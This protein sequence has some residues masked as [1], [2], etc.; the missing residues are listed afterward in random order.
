MIK[1]LGNESDDALSNPATPKRKIIVS[2]S[3]RSTTAAKTI[4]LS[5]SPKASTAPTST[6]TPTEKLKP[7]VINSQP[8][9]LNTQV[10][11]QILDSL[12]LIQYNLGVFNNSLKKINEEQASISKKLTLIEQKVERNERLTAFVTTVKPSFLPFRTFEE[13]DAYDTFDD[14]KRNE[15]KSW[16][17]NFKNEVSIKET[18]RNIL[19]ENRLFAEDLIV[20]YVYKKES[21][22]GSKKAIIKKRINHDLYDYMVSTFPGQVTHQIW[23]AILQAALKAAD[24]RVSHRKK[25]EATQD[26]TKTKKRKADEENYYT[27]AWSQSDDQKNFKL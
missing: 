21:N 17:N 26:K 15:L 20:H 8:I 23:S 12:K 1:P 16:I 5:R 18:V 2:A 22:V 7:V 10:A 24:A 4:I 3:P 19:K 9:L 25:V 6:V 11:T 14:E 13:V 27:N